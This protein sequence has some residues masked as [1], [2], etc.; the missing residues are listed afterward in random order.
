MTDL[1]PKIIEKGTYRHTKTGSL[2]E[3]LSVALHSEEGGQLVVDKAS[4]E[5]HS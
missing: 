5:Y 3:V 2:Y 4:K 1:E